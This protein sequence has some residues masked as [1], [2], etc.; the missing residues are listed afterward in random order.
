M[1]TILTIKAFKFGSQKAF[2]NKMVAI[3]DGDIVTL[4]SLIGAKVKEL[5]PFFCADHHIAKVT[6]TDQT[7]LMELL[8]RPVSLLLQSIKQSPEVLVT[9][10]AS[11]YEIEAA[12]LRFAAAE[13]QA[14]IASRNME[15]AN[16]METSATSMLETA[17]TN[18]ENA[19]KNKE[20]DQLQLESSANEVEEAAAFLKE[21]ENRW[22]VSVADVVGDAPDNVSRQKKRKVSL[23]NLPPIPATAVKEEY[24]EA[25]TMEEDESSSDG[26][27]SI[28]GK[29][30]ESLLI[31]DVVWELKKIFNVKELKNSNPTR[32]RCLQ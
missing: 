29:D 11:L 12:K 1:A 10:D 6:A 17:R 24:D 9:I 2:A 32:L 26:T 25:T 20:A 7:D 16:A 30:N 5:S 14:L 13:V 31:N 4:R 28:S 18:M 3:D 27:S 23:L 8:D 21:A 22:E 19:R 15:S